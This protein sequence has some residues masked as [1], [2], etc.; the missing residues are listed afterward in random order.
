MRNEPERYVPV[1]VLG[2]YTTSHPSSGSAVV[3]AP[4][5]G[6]L[7]RG[8]IAGAGY[9]WANRV[10]PLL[11]AL[12]RHLTFPVRGGASHE[13]CAGGCPVNRSLSSAGSRSSS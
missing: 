7:A 6:A 4:G 2:T 3:L 11:P 8:F 9:R 1:S 12:R 10:C 5:P 13:P